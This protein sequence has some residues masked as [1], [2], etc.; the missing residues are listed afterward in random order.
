[1]KS[2]KALI[3]GCERF[4]DVGTV[5][6]R[7][8]GFL[9]VEWNSSGKSGWTEKV[10]QKGKA[11]C[12]LDRVSAEVVIGA[13][14]ANEQCDVGIGLSGHELTELYGVFS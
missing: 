2:T 11:I 4:Y 3:A 7:G 6:G 9:P 10:S 8:I 12:S 1:M 14:L 5:N 13:G